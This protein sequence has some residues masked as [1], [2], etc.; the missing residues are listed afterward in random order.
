MKFQTMYDILLDYSQGEPS[1]LTQEF[2]TIRRHRRQFKLQRIKAK[3]TLQ[4]T[5]NKRFISDSSTFE[6]KPFGYSIL[7][8]RLNQ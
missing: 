2:D 3:R 4:F 1:R 5:F 7:K 8:R 6:T